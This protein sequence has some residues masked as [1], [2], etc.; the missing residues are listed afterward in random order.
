MR[1]VIVALTVVIFISFAFTSCRTK[2]VNEYTKYSGSFFGTFDTVITVVAYTKTED[3]FNKHFEKIRT[4]FEHFHKLYDIY[5]EYDGIN[6]IKTINDNAGVKAVKVDKDIIDLILFA[7]DW[8]KSTNGKLNIALGPVLSIWHDYREEGM[9]DPRNAKL[10][11]ME[12][13]REAAEYADVDKIMVDAENSTVYLADKGMSLDVG[14]VAKGYAT[15][16][17]VK[18]IMEDGLKSGIISAGGNIRVLED[19]P[20]DGVR[21]F[22]GIGI[23][24]PAKPILPDGSNYLDIVFVNNVSVVNS[25]DYERYYFVGDKRIH[26]LIDPETLMPGDYYRA[27]TI[28]TEHSGIADALSTAVF[29]MPYEQ[30]YAFVESLDGVDAMWVMKDGEVRT[31]EGMK[32]ILRSKGATYTKAN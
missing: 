23:Q 28:V 25:G 15:E 17:V 4:L 11:P 20:Y 27:V 18:E 21:E 1:R 5:N 26:H 2:T 19:K 7:K 9:N 3:E 24:D 13:L 10:P 29:L 22:W 31:T 12:Q 14:S 16:K 8:D 30:S 6:N 32:K